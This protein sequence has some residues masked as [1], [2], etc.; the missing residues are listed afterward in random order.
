MRKESWRKRCLRE[1]NE[2]QVIPDLRTAKPFGR[3]GSVRYDASAHLLRVIHHS[4]ELRIQAISTCD[5][6]LLRTSLMT[7]GSPGIKKLKVALPR[8][9]D[10]VGVLA[11]LAQALDQFRDELINTSDVDWIRFQADFCFAGNIR[12]LQG[13][14]TKREFQ[15]Q[16]SDAHKERFSDSLGDFKKYGLAIRKIDSA[17]EDE[18]SSF[19]RGLFLSLCELNRDIGI[20]LS[21]LSEWFRR[22]GSTRPIIQSIFRSLSPPVCGD[23]ETQDSAW[24]F[25]LARM[26]GEGVAM[27]HD[28]MASKGAAFRLRRQGLVHMDDDKIVE[29]WDT[30]AGKFWFRYRKDPQLT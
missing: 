22:C 6:E 30:D 15:K 18:I 29:Y 28:F 7:P 25:P 4:Y 23:G 16:A 3:K 1:L 27:A 19:F 17:S 12:S 21:V 9:H 20:H 13:K 10:A 14:T 5:L 24:F 8:L 26:Q 11:I 2:L